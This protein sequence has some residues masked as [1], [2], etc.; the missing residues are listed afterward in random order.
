MTIIG[1]TIA[2]LRKERSGFHRMLISYMELQRG[3]PMQYKQLV[4]YRSKTNRA[5]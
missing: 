5:T 4:G 1:E 2:R 3:T